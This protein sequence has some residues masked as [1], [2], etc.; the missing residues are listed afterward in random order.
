M[1]IAC[2]MAFFDMIEAMTPEARERFLR[3]QEEAARFAC[4]PAPAVSPEQPAEG[5]RKP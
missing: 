4:D 3:E 5:E 1:C 2:E